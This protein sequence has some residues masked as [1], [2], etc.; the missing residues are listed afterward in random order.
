MK[1]KNEILSLLEEMKGRLNDLSFSDKTRIENLY[2]I[3]FRYPFSKTNCGDCYRDAVIEMYAYLQKNEIMEK[4]SNYSLK[5]GVVVCV[6]KDTIVYTNKNLTD[7]V[8][9]KYLKANPK[10]IGLFASYPPDWEERIKEKPSAGS[11]KAGKA[12]KQTKTSMKGD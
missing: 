3:V 4:K 1:S 12:K 5:A 10:A 2:G 11:T 6:P 8:A 9:E 7:K